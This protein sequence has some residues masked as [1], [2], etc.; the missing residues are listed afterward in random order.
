MLREEEM[1]IGSAQKVEELLK[2]EDHHF[3][4]LF[5]E[6]AQGLLD[7]VKEKEQELDRRS[8][9]LPTDGLGHIAGNS[10]N[11][12]VHFPSI[13]SIISHCEQQNNL[14]I[15][16]NNMPE[17]C[18][19]YC[20]VAAFD[21]W[22][23]KKGFC[24]LSELMLKLWLEFSGKNKGTLFLTVAWDEIDFSQRFRPFFDHYSRTPHQVAVIL[25][26]TTGFSPVYLGH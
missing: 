9:N 2:K 19:E 11:E 25:V 1:R 3:G 7:E 6:I 16:P 26:S 14:S 12:Q 15:I 17:E 5:A 23:G 20:V 8:I 22:S 10:V 24:P 13:T 21:Q 18:K 4:K